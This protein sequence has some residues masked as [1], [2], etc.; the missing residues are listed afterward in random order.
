MCSATRRHICFVIDR[1]GIRGIKLEEAKVSAKLN[2]NFPDPP[3][4]NYKADVSS[5]HTAHQYS[6]VHLLIPLEQC[7]M[8][9]ALALPESE[10][11]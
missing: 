6:S 3:A 8:F 4:I 7:E 11:H 9:K 5:C 10:G 2:S 1:R